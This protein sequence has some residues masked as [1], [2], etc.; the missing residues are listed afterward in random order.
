[1]D[2]KD[3]IIARIDDLSKRTK[4]LSFRYAYDTKTDFHIVEIEPYEIWR[5]NEEYIK[6]ECYLWLAFSSLFPREDLLI[7]ERHRTNDMSNI[8]YEKHSKLNNMDAK[9][10][11]NNMSNII[12]DAKDF[13]IAR[14][15]DISAR[16]K[17][18]SFRY[19]YETK[20]DFHI[21]EVTPEEIRRGNEEYIKLECDLWIA[22]SSLLP[23]EDILICGKCDIND[24]SNII[25]EKHSD[26]V[27]DSS[28]RRD[29]I[30]ENNNCPAA[31][32]LAL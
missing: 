5:G 8:I 14:I 10:F 32:S 1:M 4:G 17:G 27:N 6:I 26:A 12:M 30:F 31:Y 2:A 19:A 23:K 29:F 22:F 20:T 24:M 7:S 25:Y 18:I 13:I 11:T 21:V 28:N 15:D 3:F 16:I 9:D